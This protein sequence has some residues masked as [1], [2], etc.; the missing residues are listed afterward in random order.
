MREITYTQ[1]I[2]EAYDEELKQ[3]N[4]QDLLTFTFMIGSG[5]LSQNN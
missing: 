3:K 1:A 2:T 4:S 5:T